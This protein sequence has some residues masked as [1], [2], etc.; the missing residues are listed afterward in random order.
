MSA[1]Q[2]WVFTWSRCCVIWPRC[3]W[4]SHTGPDHYLDTQCSETYPPIRDNYSVV[5]TNQRRVLPGQCSCRC[6]G[7]RCCWTT[8]E[9]SWRVG[10]VGLI[11]PLVCSLNVLVDIRNTLA[12]VVSV[13]TN[14][15]LVCIQSTNQKRVFTCILHQDWGESRWLEECHCQDTE[16]CESAEVEDLGFADFSSTILCHSL[17][18]QP[19]RG[20]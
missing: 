1:N 5:S 2:R 18:C 12:T 7:S 20:Q 8:L 15:R 6:G 14:Q 13:S 16:A 10:C 19:I 9:V 11:K 3:C 4:G 17:S